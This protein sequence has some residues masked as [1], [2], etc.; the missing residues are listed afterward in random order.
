[1][2]RFSTCTE[3]NRKICE[4]WGDNMKWMKLIKK[5][6]LSS[7][8]AA[9]GNLIVAV[10]KMVVAVISGN[11]TMYATA[12]HSFADTINQLFVFIVSVLS[13]MNPTERFPKG[14]GRLINIFCMVAVIVVT[15]MAYETIKTG[16]T[17]FMDPK[18][19]TNFLLNIIVLVIAFLI[20]GIILYKTMKEIIHEAKVD[21]RSNLLIDAFK[22]A[23]RAS[24]ATK[25]VFYEDIVATFGA[26][27]AIS[28]IML[29]Q[30]FG[31][32]RADGIVSIIIGLLML[33]V[34]FRVGY[35]NM[36]GLIG[37]AAPAEVE[38]QIG[39]L[40]LADACVVDIN[41]L[42]VMQ[43]GRAYHVDAMVELRKG[44]TLAEADDLVFKLTDKLLKSPNITD[45]DL[46]IIEDDDQQ[47]WPEE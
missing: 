10:V 41:K 26:V 37:V 45:V 32:L 35:D 38:K 17:L 14:F 11:G 5:G 8:L 22:Y 34:V 9:L 20:D 47:S 40:I 42:R 3:I 15:L 6:N 13:E 30:F 23:K 46:M 21:Q 24:P 39:E 27:L 43:E 1:M 31:L 33:F 12:M 25:L 19:S 16:W 29:S 4:R 18:A 2:Y 44:L 36:V 7:G 28:G